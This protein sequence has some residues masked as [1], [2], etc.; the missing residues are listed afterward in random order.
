MAEISSSGW[1]RSTYFEFL[2]GR[3]GNFPP[4]RSDLTANLQTQLVKSYYSDF[5]AVYSRGTIKGPVRLE[6]EDKP[7]CKT[8][9]TND[10]RDVSAKRTRIGIPDI[11]LGNADRLFPYRRFDQSLVQ[12]PPSYFAK[13]LADH[14]PNTCIHP[15]RY[16]PAWSGHHIS[17][18]EARVMLCKY[19]TSDFQHNDMI[20]K[21]ALEI[22]TRIENL[23]RRPGDAWLLEMRHL[24]N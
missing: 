1:L 10:I 5:I 8:T 12:L 6:T 23:V 9:T 13:R 22:E 16:H 24:G 20:R 11:W 19:V 3:R 2:L 7:R 15:S 17:A 4:L 21:V 14:Q 18:S